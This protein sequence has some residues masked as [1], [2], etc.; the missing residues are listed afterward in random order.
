M[1]IDVYQNLIIKIEIVIKK[2]LEIRRII[3]I[4]KTIIILILLI[5]LMLIIYRDI[6]LKNKDFLF[7]SLYKQDFE[8]E[9]NVFV[10]IVNF[11]FFFI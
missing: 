3:R 8:Y 4:K 1:I 5:I 7:E 6:L 2:N 9:K 10:Y 11:S